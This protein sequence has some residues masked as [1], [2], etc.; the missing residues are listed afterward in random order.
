[1]NTDQTTEPVVEQKL[2][3]GTAV[4]KHG[5][6]H[7]IVAEEPKP[8][9]P[10]ATE[11]PVTAAIAEAAAAVKQTRKKPAK[12]NG[13]KKAVAKAVPKAPREGT[14]LRT[15]FDAARTAKGIDAEGS[16]K[17]Y[18]YDGGLWVTI[19]QLADAHNL[20]GA[21]YQEGRKCYY[22]LLRRGQ[23]PGA[24]AKDVYTPKAA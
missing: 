13:S 9:E 5:D 10:A 18:G 4:A 7:V 20:V 24:K 21:K 11:K 8:V 19:R 3:E 1:M 6:G 12:K 17:I 14:K 2:D 15:F 16:R 22:R 23:K